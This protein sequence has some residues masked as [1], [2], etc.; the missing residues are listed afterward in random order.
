MHFCSTCQN[1][2]YIR[3]DSENTNQLIYYCRNCGNEDNLITNDSVSILKTH[4][5][6]KRTRICAFY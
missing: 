5:K 2:Y 1:M 3:M 4:I 6:K